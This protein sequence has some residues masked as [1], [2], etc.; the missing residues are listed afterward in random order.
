MRLEETQSLGGRT[1]GDMMESE[2]EGEK[3]MVAGAT[4]RIFTPHS[5]KKGHLDSTQ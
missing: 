3:Y 1:Q 4:Q 2:T 5:I